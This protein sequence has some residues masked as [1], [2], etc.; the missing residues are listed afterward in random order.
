MDPLPAVLRKQSLKSPGSTV[1]VQGSFIQRD[2]NVRRDPNKKVLWQKKA[3]RQKD[4]ERSP[5]CAAGVMHCRGQRGQDWLR[6][7][8]DILKSC[9]HDWHTVVAFSSSS[10]WWCVSLLCERAGEG[11]EGDQLTSTYYQAALYILCRAVSVMLSATFLAALS[12][13]PSLSVIGYFGNHWQ[14]RS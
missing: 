6:H 7:F 8:K 9:A 4:G 12:S 3:N 13:L 14:Q 1:G 10:H 11:G 5:A 2:V